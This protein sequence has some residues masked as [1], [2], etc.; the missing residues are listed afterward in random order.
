MEECIQ[1][2]G[3]KP[4]F[5][6]PVTNILDKKQE[7]EEGKKNIAMDQLK[8][9]IYAK[10]RENQFMAHVM[11]C[12][13][14]GKPVRRTDPLDN[15]SVSRIEE[16]RRKFNRVRLIRSYHSIKRRDKQRKFED[17][18]DQLGVEYSKENMNLDQ[19][20]YCVESDIDHEYPRR[21]KRQ[22]RNLEQEVMLLRLTQFGLYKAPSLAEKT[23]SGPV[24]PVDEGKMFGNILGE[25]SVESDPKEAVDK[26]LD[27]FSVEP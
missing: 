13:T 14:F 7:H 10:K 2:A 8:P 24:T 3:R 23:N 6:Y 9:V 1:E 26:R 27:V 19:Q 4:H 22:K 25:T 5:G 16:M 20:Q 17:P 11:K 18:L 21:T 12:F 15:E